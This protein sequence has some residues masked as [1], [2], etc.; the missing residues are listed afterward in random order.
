MIKGLVLALALGAPFQCASDPDPEHR[1][2]DS[3]AEALWDLAARLEREGHS[4]A[5]RSTLEQ[6]IERYPG[7]REAR[8]ARH[9]LGLETAD[10][11]DDS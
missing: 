7:S 3:P 8:R 9:E 10:N 6:L 2:E 1:L 4:E 11:D 5:R